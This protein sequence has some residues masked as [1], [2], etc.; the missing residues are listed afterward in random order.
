MYNRIQ[1]IPVFKQSHRIWIG[2]ILTAGNHGLGS[3]SSQES[4]IVPAEATIAPDISSSSDSKGPKTVTATSPTEAELK[5]GSTE[6]FLQGFEDAIPTANFGLTSEFA[7]AAKPLDAGKKL[8]VGF[9]F[10]GSQ[11]DLGYNQAAAEGSQYLEKA[12]LRH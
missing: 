6:I 9:I 10:V 3:L 1:Q 5:G 11:K 7:A 2:G 4:T 12:L 8:K